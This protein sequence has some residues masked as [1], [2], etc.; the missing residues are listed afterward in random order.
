MPTYHLQLPQ[1]KAFKVILLNKHKQFLF[2]TFSLKINH[3]S[4][5]GWQLFNEFFGI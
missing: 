5:L 2:T 1:P 4:V 3:L